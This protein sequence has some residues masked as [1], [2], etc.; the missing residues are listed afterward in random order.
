MGLAAGGRMRQQLYP[1]PHGLDTWD[2]DEFGRVFVHIVNS[3]EWTRITGEP[4]PPT[5]VDVRSYIAAGLPWFDLYD[6][7]LGDIEP[8]GVLAGVKSVDELD[9]QHVA[10]GVW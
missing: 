7:H 8:S 3:H 1:D 9:A 2:Q 10:D 6:D 5:P 4:L